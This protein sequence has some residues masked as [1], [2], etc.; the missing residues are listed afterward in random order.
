M[1]NLIMFQ[2]TWLSGTFL[3][4]T[5]GLGKSTESCLWPAL[6]TSL[7]SR[8]FNIYARPAP[9]QGRLCSDRIHSCSQLAASDTARNPL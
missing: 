3:R 6:L 2:N 7:K 5:L 8:L 4:P 1:S 9:S